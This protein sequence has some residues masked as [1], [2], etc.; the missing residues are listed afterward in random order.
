M[1]ENTEFTSHV[2][3]PDNVRTLVRKLCRLNLIQLLEATVLILGLILEWTVIAITHAV[4]IEA[5]HL[6]TVRDN[7]AILTV[8]D[9]GGTNAE[10]LPV[11]DLARV[12]LG[13][14]ELPKQLTGLF[15]KT[16][17]DAL[18]A[19]DPV[20]AGFL[21]VRP[22]VNP[23]VFHG[24]GSVGLRPHFGNP[25]EMLGALGFAFVVELTGSEV[26]RKPLRGRHHV[27]AAVAAPLWPFATAGGGFFGVSHW[28]ANEQC[29]A[30]ER[31][32]DRLKHDFH[33]FC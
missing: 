11:G 33:V 14:G 7:V 1:R 32:P 27:I 3:S 9:E 12:K 13:N 6:T 29:C 16:H 24:R 2:I 10:E 15:V 5:D 8:D 31:E 18:V 25:L 23:T 28:Q 26:N 30:Q 17:H 21:V 19:G 22:D 4:D 20:E